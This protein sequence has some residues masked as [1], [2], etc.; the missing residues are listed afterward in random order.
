M[1]NSDIHSDT[2][3]NDGSE[4]EDDIQLI[5]D[6]YYDEDEPCEADEPR[7]EI[8][9]SNQAE[10]GV[11]L[12][13]EEDNQISPLNQARTMSRGLTATY[14]D[15][16]PHNYDN[17]DSD[18]DDSDDDLEDDL[19]IE[20]EIQAGNNIPP[21]NQAE[22]ENAYFND[23][24]EDHIRNSIPGISNLID[25]FSNFEDSEP[26]ESPVQIIEVPNIDSNLP[27]RIQA[28]I[29]N[30]VE[31]EATQDVP[32]NIHQAVDNLFRQ[33]LLR[34]M[35]SP[36]IQQFL[37]SVQA[38]TRNDTPPVVRNTTMSIASRINA[39]LGINR[40]SDLDR[41]SIG[42]RFLLSR[43]ERYSLLE[44]RQ[45]R[46]W[47]FSTIY[48][49]ENEITVSRSILNVI[50]DLWFDTGCERFPTKIEII[51]K[52][53]TIPCN[54]HLRFGQRQLRDLL[55]FYVFR[56]GE[57]PNCFQVENAIEYYVLMQRYPTMQELVQYIYTNLEF[58]NN[59]EDYF[60]RDRVHVPAINLDKLP[61]CQGDGEV[62]CAICQDEITTEQVAV[63]LKPC[64]HQYHHDRD[65]CLTE[66]GIY[67]WLREHNFC[68]MCKQKVNSDT[69]SN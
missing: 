37:T 44:Y 18:S 11:R 58:F 66:G 39:F 48:E 41:A 61:K 25:F 68:P 12:L 53:L 8:P 46:E 65:Q 29:Q 56:E 16:A 24:V 7:E 34:N 60:Q 64:N 14:V 45:A 17:Y 6:T 62:V 15:L 31:N 27:G 10:N 2:N 20:A 9:P 4:S 59:P 52:L 55:E 40:N 33:H 26:I 21:R 67:T 19:E 3:S 32:I 42:R 1:D 36:D 69:E 43:D 13:I 35:L 30:V 63:V 49:G 57:I 38:V 54:C 51:D 50:C 23:L 5:C 28:E 22:N 47:Y